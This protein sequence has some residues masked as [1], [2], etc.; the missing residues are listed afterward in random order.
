MVFR[1]VVIFVQFC[2]GYSYRVGIQVSV[3]VL[4]ALFKFQKERGLGNSCVDKSVFWLALFRVA[5]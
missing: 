3:R 2:L 5:C 1:I 4:G